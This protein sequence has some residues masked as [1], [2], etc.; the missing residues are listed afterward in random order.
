MSK[1]ALYL[2]TKPTLADYQKYIKQMIAERGFQDESIAELLML[3]MEECGELARACR[4]FTS[5]KSDSKRLEKENID[6]ELA[7]IFM[8]ILA[9]SNKFEIDLEQAFR[10]K[11]AINKQ[12]IWQ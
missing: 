12:R 3:L 5:L 10:K 7:D 9:I 1:K 2:K 8:Y 11:E 4:K 6:L